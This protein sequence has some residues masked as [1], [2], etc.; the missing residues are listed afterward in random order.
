MRP[1]FSPGACRHAAADTVAL[2]TFDHGMT[3][4]GAC[5]RSEPSGDCAYGI[6]LKTLHPA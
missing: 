5:H 1:T 4:M 6:P 2:R 3:G